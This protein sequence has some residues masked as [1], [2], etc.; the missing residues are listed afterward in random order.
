MAMRLT[1]VNVL[2]CALVDAKQSPFSVRLTQARQ[3]LIL[4]SRTIHTPH[5]APTS[6]G[7]EE[8]PGPNHE[9]YSDPQAEHE[10]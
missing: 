6:V 8:T 1:P 3:T 2:A 4:R 9:L 10:G 7:A 5:A